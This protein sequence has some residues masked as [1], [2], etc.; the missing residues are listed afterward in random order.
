MLH[1]STTEETPELRFFIFTQI[2]QHNGTKT[3]EL[4]ADTDEK[5]KSRMID[6]LKQGREG[7]ILVSQAIRYTLKDMDGEGDWAWLNDD[8]LHEFYDAIDEEYE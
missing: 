4:I 2:N 3:I 6:T 8:E 7:Y 1:I 5:G